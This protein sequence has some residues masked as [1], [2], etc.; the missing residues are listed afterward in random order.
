VQHDVAYWWLEITHSPT[1]DS[2]LYRKLACENSCPDGEYEAYSLGC[3]DCPET[4]TVSKA[5]T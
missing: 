1:G 3:E 5:G 4:M 2:C